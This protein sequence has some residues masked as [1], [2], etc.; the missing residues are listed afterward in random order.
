MYLIHITIDPDKLPAGQAESLL[1][2]HRAWFK[3]HFDAG[4][5]LLLGPYLDQP[6]AGVIVAHT[7][8]R[9]ALQRLLAEDVYHAPGWA[10]YDVREFKAVMVSPQL[11][12]LQ[13]A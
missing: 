9:D 5:F 6:H 2:Q 11:A 1:V 12:G 3:Q 10:S 4:H 8:S 7:P 13:G